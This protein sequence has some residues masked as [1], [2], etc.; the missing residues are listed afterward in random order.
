[1]AAELMKV[2]LSDTNEARMHRLIQSC[3]FPSHCTVSGS[4]KMKEGNGPLAHG[5]G[6]AEKL[7]KRRAG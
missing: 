3:V 6:V 2:Q 5:G 7:R 1:M 4:C